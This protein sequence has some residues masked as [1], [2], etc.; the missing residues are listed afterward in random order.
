MRSGRFKLLFAVVLCAGVLVGVVPAQEEP[1]VPL[2]P[3]N[4][5][6]PYWRSVT[7]RSEHL[8]PAEEPDPNEQKAIAISGG[9]RILDDTGL[10]GIDDQ[11][12]EIVAYDQD[13]V[14]IYASV[15]QRH[16]MNRRYE[17]ITGA[18]HLATMMGRDNEL[19]FT[20]SLPIAPEADYPSALSRVEWSMKVLMANDFMTVDVPFEPNE[21]WVELV[22]GLELLVEEA[23]VEEGEYSYR[24]QAIYDPNLASFS[25]T[26]RWHFWSDEALPAVMMTAMEMLNA[27]GNPVYEPGTSGGFGSSGGSGVSDGLGTARISGHGRCASC[28]DATTIRF[29]FALAPYEGEARLALENIPISGF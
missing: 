29:T 18:T 22:P 1:N 7:L 19:R 16:L 2:D 10:I 11:E 27:E 20:V 23:S 8:N 13:G 6:E 17:A 26:D 25:T 3:A 9:I 15:D 28:G 12:R 21:A 5:F 4:Y 14:E 24:M